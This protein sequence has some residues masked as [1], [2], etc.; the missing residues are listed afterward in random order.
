MPALRQLEPSAVVPRLRRY[1]RQR[2]GDWLDAQARD[3]GGQWPLAI[4][5][6][7][8]TEREAGRSIETVRIWIESWQRW[9]GR[10]E[11]LWI[12]RAWADLGRQRLP[13]RLLL[14]APADIADWLEEGERWCRALER[15]D[16]L[17]ARFPTLSGRL[18][19]HFDWLADASEL[20]LGRLIQVLS[21]LTSERYLGFY[22]RQLPIA[23]IDSKWI[24]AN[25]ARVTELLRPLLFPGEGEAD[26]AG[27]LWSIAGLRREPRLL[28]LRLLDQRL[29]RRVGGLADISA[30]ADELA[31]LRLT[32]ERVFIVENIQTGLA[33]TDY[34]AGTVIFGL[35]YAVDCLG[36]IPWLRDADCRYWGDLDT[37]G[38]AILDRLRVYI[39]PVRSLLMDEPTLLDHREL[40]S[41]EDKAVRDLELPRLD[42]AERSVYTGLAGDRWGSA[43]RLEQERI[44]W[45]YAWER[46]VAG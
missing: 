33:F 8:P 39:P 24:G 5:L 29:R 4:L 16:L 11:V 2:K 43:V 46:I 23:G 22:L 17:R 13:E 10:G 40:W 26:G 12:E 41:R 18:G 31:A 38:L 27:D 25:R 30:P 35:G 45:D 28:R 21:A 14:H 19:R 9:Q 44:G 32:P 1:W 20:E 15:R 34:P 37:H 3:D 42:E 7:P 6:H 36:Q